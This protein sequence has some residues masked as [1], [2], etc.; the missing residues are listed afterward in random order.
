MKE[1]YSPQKLS[2]KICREYSLTQ[3]DF[4]TFV[5]I[6]ASEQNQNVM[7]SL[8]KIRDNPVLLRKYFK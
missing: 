7:K 2:Q 4:Q 8:N 5:Q 1:K 3:K 6:W